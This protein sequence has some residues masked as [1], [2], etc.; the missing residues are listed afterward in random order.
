[1]M[2][3]IPIFLITI[4]F[5]L[6]LPPTN[7]KGDFHCSVG[8]SKDICLK[9]DYAQFELPNT[10]SV[11]EIHVS[12]NLDEVYRVDDKDGSITFSAYFNVD[13]NERRLFVEPKVAALNKGLIHMSPEFVKDLWL[14]NIYI[15]NMKSYSVLDVYS[16]L[17]G[18]WIDTNKSVL[19]SQAAQISFVCPMNFKRFPLDEQRC[20][21]RVGS[22]SYD[23]SKMIFITKEFGYSSYSK[24]VNRNSPPLDYDIGK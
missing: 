18:L 1:M 11:N 14:P 4:T 16:K 9:D 10:D 6:S 7:G 3:V 8:V 13:W 15:Y 24:N 12:L 5:V 17:S 21:F 22:Y 19:Y 20:K 2:S 23:M